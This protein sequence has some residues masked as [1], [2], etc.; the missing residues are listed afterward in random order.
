[1]LLRSRPQ[2]F[3]SANHLFEVKWD[4][5]RV[6]CF[7]DSEGYRI[8]SRNGRDIT[9]TYPE[10][11]PALIKLPKGTSLDGELVVMRGGAPDFHALM[12]RDVC[13]R[14]TRIAALV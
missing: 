9:A 12:Q 2:P 1:M 5:M 8:Y 13:R 3:D 14:Q 11:A 10:L 7:R 6:L 4:G